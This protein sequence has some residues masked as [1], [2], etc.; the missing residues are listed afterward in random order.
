[1]LSL[2][3]NNSSMECVNSIT[4]TKEAKKQ[5]MIHILIR[6]SEL[7]HDKSIYYQSIYYRCIKA[8][9]QIE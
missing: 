2:Q 5:G 7:F 9:T 8:N 3:I 4:I 1:M 6:P